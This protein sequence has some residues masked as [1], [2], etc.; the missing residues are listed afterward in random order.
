MARFRFNLQAVLQHRKMVEEQKQR[1]LAA[2]EAERARLE[3][4]IRA[5]QQAITEERRQMRQSLGVGDIR[6]VRLQSAA[7][8][9]LATA[10][11]RAVLEL[12]GLHRRLENARAELLEASKRRKAVELLRERRYE[13][14]KSEQNRRELAALDELAVMAAARKEVDP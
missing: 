13:E 9:R 10:A 5:H 11:Q 12:A 3:S 1:A 7:S 6:A 8:V 4:V 2:L 14:W